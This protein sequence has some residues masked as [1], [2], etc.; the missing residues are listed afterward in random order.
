MSEPNLVL[1]PCRHGRDDDAK[2]CL[3]CNGSGYV[4]VMPGVEG[5]PLECQHASAKGRIAK[6]IPCLRY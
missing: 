4:K 5:H 6:C 3:A 1:V 2:G